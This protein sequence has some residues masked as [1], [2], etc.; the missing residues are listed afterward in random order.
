MLLQSHPT[1]W[2]RQYNCL[3]FVESVSPSYTGKL[4]M[5]IDDTDGVQV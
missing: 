1:L 5:D 2:K 3:E 4:S